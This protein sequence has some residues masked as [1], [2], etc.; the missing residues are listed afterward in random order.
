M[1]NEHGDV[2]RHIPM[3]IGVFVALAVFT[4]LT[5][6]ASRLHA[7]TSTHVMMALAIAVVKGSLVAAIFMH[8]RWEKAPI[9]WGVIFLCALCFAALMLLPTLTV[10]DLPPGVR[11]G[12]WG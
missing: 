11:M 5:V 12:T 3:Y 8:L 1:A 7:T 2:S 10:G 4:V 9:L 6:I